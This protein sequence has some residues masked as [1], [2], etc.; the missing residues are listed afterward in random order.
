M[1][2][3]NIATKICITKGQEA[4]VWGWQEVPGLQG[5]CILDTLFIKLLNP[6]N[7]IKLVGLPLNVVPLTRNAMMTVCS[8][9]DDTSIT[10]SCSQIKVLPNFSMTD[11]ASQGKTGENNVIDLTYSWSHQGYYMALSRGIC[12]V[13]TLILGGFHPNK[14]MGG[15]SGALWQEFREL[16]LL[17]NITALHFEGKLPWKAA[18]ESR[19]GRSQK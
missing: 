17:D 9:P 2:R 3:N 14:I 11:Y 19:N 13:G 16:E 10:V 18:M 15:V 8:L 1:L 4:E 5:W 12:T 6:P 7:N